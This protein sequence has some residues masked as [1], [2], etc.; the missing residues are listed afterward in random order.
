MTNNTLLAGEITEMLRDWNDNRSD[1]SAE[2]LV[3]LVY[4]ERRGQVRVKRKLKRFFF[5][6]NTRQNRFYS[7]S[8]P[9]FCSKYLDPICFYVCIFKSQIG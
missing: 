5:V 4:D 9:V 8:A 2:A 7:F 1:D 3:K 6:R